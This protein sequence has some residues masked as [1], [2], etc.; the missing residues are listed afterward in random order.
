M[1]LTCNERIND[2][3]TSSPGP[4]RI[5]TSE[6]QGQR[7]LDGLHE[8]VAQSE[9]EAEFVLSEEYWVRYYLEEYSGAYGFEIIGD[10]DNEVRGRRGDYRII[11]E[12]QEMVLE[13]EKD[14]KH[15]F[16]HGHDTEGTVG[17]DTPGSI[18][19]VFAVT[20]NNARKEEF[21]I[22]VIIAA[23]YDS[24]ELNEPTFE[25]WY[26][27]VREIKSVK[28][29]FVFSFISAVYWE[30][31]KGTP[32]VEEVQKQ[33][34]EI[35]STSREYLSA[36]HEKLWTAVTGGVN[37]VLFNREVA[38]QEGEDFGD[39]KSKAMPLV[40]DGYSETTEWECPDCSEPFVLIGT[41][42]RV[43][44]PDFETMSEGQWADQRAAQE[45]GFFEEGVHGET[46]T[47]MYCF[48]CLIGGVASPRDAEPLLFDNRSEVEFK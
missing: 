40:Q 41:H 30:Y 4:F 38:I 19:L 20:D 46:L 25:E 21:D 13:V 3:L 48:D 16:E 10:L 24:S 8:V 15:F 47:V 37:D 45:G 6:E 26:N 5:K 35:D 27:R 12:G 44:E 33:A 17:W 23:D 43:Y 11:Y 42:K 34:G 29:A 1:E 39:L 22:P 32:T 7:V 14:L 28:E 18:D 36:I 9:A 2:L 31:S